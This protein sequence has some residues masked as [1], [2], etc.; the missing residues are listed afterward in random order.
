VRALSVSCIYLHLSPP[1]V[2]DKTVDIN[3]VFGTGVDALWSN[4]PLLTQPGGEFSA[5]VAAGLLA[6]VSP[7]Q[8]ATT[9]T[10]NAR[11]YAETLRALAAAPARIAALKRDLDLVRRAEPAE[12]CESAAGS[13]SGGGGRDG[14]QRD[15]WR[16]AE[17]IL[18]DGVRWVRS[19]ESGLRRAVEIEVMGLAPMHLT[20][21]P[22]CA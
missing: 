4:T 2:P 17:G 13:R 20:P 15:G 18:F 1:T 14:M 7:R 16:H 11:D 3:S 19:W 12:V 5:R 21:G 9:V 22:V 6:G 8:F 10:R